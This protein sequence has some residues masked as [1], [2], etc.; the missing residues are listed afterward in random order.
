MVAG[1]ILT[2]ENELLFI[3][4]FICS[5]CYHGKSAALRS[6]TQLR[7]LENTALSAARFPLRTPLYVKYSVKL[8]NILINHCLSLL[9]IKNNVTKKHASF[10]DLWFYL[11]IKFTALENLG[12]S[13]ELFCV[14]LALIV[15]IFKIIKLAVILLFKY[16]HIRDL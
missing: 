13:F 10:T 12:K 11:L 14:V 1:W 16:I 4:I 6:A 2:R 3:N 7:C 5:L 9:V 15:T 8:I